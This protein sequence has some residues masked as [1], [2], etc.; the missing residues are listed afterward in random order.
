LGLICRPIHA[1]SRNCRLA[2][3]GIPLLLN[4]NPGPS[5]DAVSGTGAVPDNAI[6]LI[7]EGCTKERYDASYVKIPGVNGQVESGNIAKE[8][9]SAATGW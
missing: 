2:V 4:P 9:L 1:K 7:V 5:D 8:V 3:R 6:R